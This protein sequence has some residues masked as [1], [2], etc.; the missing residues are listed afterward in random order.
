MLQRRRKTIADLQRKLEE[1]SGTESPKRPEGDAADAAQEASN[2]ADARANADI[3]R[4][5]KA[6]NLFETENGVE[7]ERRIY[8]NVYMYM[9][10]FFAIHRCT[11]KRCTGIY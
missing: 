7:D 1:K 3:E 2:E 4:P 11:L 9:Y 8:A 6:L 5:Q 10:I